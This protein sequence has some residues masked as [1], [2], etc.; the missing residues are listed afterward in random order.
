MAK[1]F[2]NQLG[3]SFIRSVVNQVGRDGGKVISNQI[4]GNQHSTPIRIVANVDTGKFEIPEGVHIKK[5]YTILKIICAFFLSLIPYL[6][7]AILIYRGIVN[8]LRKTRKLYKTEQ[9]AN[10]VQDRRYKSGARYVGST[11]VEVVAGEVEDIKYLKV[12]LVK[13]IIYLLIGVGS[14][15][16]FIYTV[17]YSKSM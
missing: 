17:Y 5:D 13:G 15:V 7:G 11:N 9:K 12:C 14:I 2:L 1:S 4:Y 8:C 6:G 16:F 10:Y 3:K